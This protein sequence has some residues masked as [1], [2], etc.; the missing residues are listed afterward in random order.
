MATKITAGTWCTYGAHQVLV[1]ETWENYL[2]TPDEWIFIRRA[3]VAIP[4]DTQLYQVDC[5]DLVPIPKEPVRV[6]YTGTDPWIQKVFGVL[7]DKIPAF[8]VQVMDGIAQVAS[9]AWPQT[10][11]VPL[12]DLKPTPKRGLCL[13][14]LGELYF[15]FDCAHDL[16]GDQAKYLDESNLPD[17]TTAYPSL[18][19]SA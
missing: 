1:L 16:W 17:L 13:M 2:E 11:F 9:E 15:R 5:R 19:I 14:S 12:D 8:V 7:F 10:V 18:A 4:G 6:T 3:K